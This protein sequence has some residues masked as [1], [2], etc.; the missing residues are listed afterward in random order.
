MY[1]YNIVYLQSDEYWITH[2]CLINYYLLAND[3]IVSQQLF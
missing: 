2:S 1:K 3:S